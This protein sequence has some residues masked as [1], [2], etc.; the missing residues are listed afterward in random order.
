M[1]GVASYGKL[2]QTAL[3]KAEGEEDM[4][5]KN[6]F[7]VKPVGRDNAILVNNRNNM[8]FQGTCL[9]GNSK[10]KTSNAIIHPLGERM[11]MSSNS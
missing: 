6:S 10:G 4:S 5:L 1:E 2:E 7:L 9:P 11:G 3:S 8:Y